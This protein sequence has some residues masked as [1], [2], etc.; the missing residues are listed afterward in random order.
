LCRRFIR[1]EINDGGNFTIVELTQIASI[2]RV[3]DKEQTM[4]RGSNQR[5]VTAAEIS[6]E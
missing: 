4:V 3:A 6:V 1:G 2:D 5:D